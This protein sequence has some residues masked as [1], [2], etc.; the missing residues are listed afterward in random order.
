MT[1]CTIEIKLPVE[2]DYYISDE[3]NLHVCNMVYEIEIVEDKVD[4]K[5]F[6]LQRVEDETRIFTGEITCHKY[7]N[8]WSNFCD[9]SG[10]SHNICISNI[11]DGIYMAAA[12]AIAKQYYT[13]HAIL[14]G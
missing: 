14:K 6:T 11:D 12:G 13:E 5:Y 7:E 2:V 8:K 9:V 10:F 3:G 1:S 4:F